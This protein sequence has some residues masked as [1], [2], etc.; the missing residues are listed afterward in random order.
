M[1]RA[2]VEMVKYYKPKLREKCSKFWGELEV[3]KI[4]TISLSQCQYSSH[5]RVFD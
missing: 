4:L 2:Q 5:D 3:L 1:I